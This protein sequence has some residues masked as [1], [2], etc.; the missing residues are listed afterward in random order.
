M[1][2]RRSWIVLAIGAVGGLCWI[3]FQRASGGVRVLT[4]E[5]RWAIGP[6]PMYRAGY[7]ATVSV[8]NEEELFKIVE[9][10]V[11][12]HIQPRAD[13]VQRQTDRSLEG[14]HGWVVVPL[15]PHEQASDQAVIYPRSEGDK[16]STC[17]VD[18]K[19]SRQ[20]R[21]A[22]RPDSQIVEQVIEEFKGSPRSPVGAKGW[23]RSKRGG[24]RF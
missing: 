13:T 22:S 16:Q 12:F 8:G 10:L 23:G 11:R 20:R 4:T 6:G 3:L 14:G 21:F 5:C 1:R 7:A 2:S 17:V 9:L 24:F 15:G 18:V 19:V